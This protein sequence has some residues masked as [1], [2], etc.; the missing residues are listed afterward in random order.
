MEF[1]LVHVEAWAGLRVDARTERKVDYL[2]SSSLIDHLGY[3][4][5]HLLA[6]HYVALHY[7]QK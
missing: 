5:S 1:R 2:S 3:R 4:S 6:A 7:T